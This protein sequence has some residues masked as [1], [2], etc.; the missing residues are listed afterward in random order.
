MIEKDCCDCKVVKCI[1][2]DSIIPKEELCGKSRPTDCY[3]YEERHKLDD[4]GCWLAA[5]K[6]KESDAVNSVSLNIE[7]T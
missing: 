1:D 4:K 6:E 7:S 2:C 3:E 5:C